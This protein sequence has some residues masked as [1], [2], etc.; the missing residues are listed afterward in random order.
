MRKRTA[1]L[2]ACLLCAGCAAGQANKKKA[3]YVGDARGRASIEVLPSLDVPESELTAEMRM[4]RLLS[5][6]SLELPA[7]TLPGDRSAAQLSDWSDSQLKDWLSEKQ[8]RAEAA[9]AELDRAAAQ[10]HRQRIVAGALVGLVY[11]DIARTLLSIPLPAELDTEPEVAD[12]FR[13]LMAKQAAPFLL[14]AELAYTAC[15]GNAAG[16]ESM[17]HWSEFCERRGE[18]LPEKALAEQPAP[19]HTAQ[20]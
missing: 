11:E 1:S 8:Q 10:N 3:V 4:A 16:L 6:E 17:A 19:E 15:A 12:L 9:R 13:E 5:A 14:H 7:P 18:G 20:R 2:V